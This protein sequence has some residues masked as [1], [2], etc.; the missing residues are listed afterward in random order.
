MQ[1]VMAEPSRKLMTPDEFYLWIW[2][3]DQDERYELVEAIL[4]LA[5]LY[6]RLES[7]S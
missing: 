5:A 3:I 1:V 4:P 2:Q 7:L 6:D